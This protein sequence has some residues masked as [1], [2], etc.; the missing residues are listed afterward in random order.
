[1]SQS[2]INSRR[3]SPPWAWPS[4][5]RAHERRRA[6]SGAM[7]HVCGVQANSVT[8]ITPTTAVVVVVEHEIWLTEVHGDHGAPHDRGPSSRRGPRRRLPSATAVVSSITVVSMTGASVQTRNLVHTAV[9]SS[10]V[11]TPRMGFPRH[12]TAG[13]L[14]G[15]ILRESARPAAA[16]RMGARAAV[17]RRL[18]NF[19]WPAGGPGGQLAGGNGGEGRP[20]QQPVAGKKSGTAP[21]HFP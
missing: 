12:R 7:L 13:P 9:L 11:I 8:T 16:G 21:E 3:P 1:M 18:R 5:A 10:T 20:W 4:S 15:T 14:P 2:G 17:G 6:L 19:E